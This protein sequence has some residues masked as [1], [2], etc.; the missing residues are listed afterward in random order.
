MN[1]AWLIQQ[2][3]LLTA[4]RRK[5]G[6]VLSLLAMGLL[7]WG[8]LLLKEVPRVATAD[9][10]AEAQ[11]ASD[12]GEGSGDDA[13]S[14]ARVERTER[15]RIDPPRSLPRDLFVFDPNPY[16]RTGSPDSPSRPEKSDR[17]ADEQEIRVAAARDAAAG[18]ILS[19]VM[20]GPRPRA[21]I[22]GRVLAEGQSIE[23]FVVRQI[24]QRHALLERD[25][26]VV[27]LRM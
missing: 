13:D 3:R 26:L 4:D 15:V 27:R 25:G 5:A 7:L 17:E 2:W 14:Q 19:S 22:N 1:R 10:E 9:P 24:G 11:A 20:R 6:L 21:V 12:G 8:R 16:R 23:G 18:L